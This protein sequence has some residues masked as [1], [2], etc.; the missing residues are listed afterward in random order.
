MLFLVS[1]GV[2]CFAVLVSIVSLIWNQPYLKPI[3]ILLMCALAGT[4]AV[5][6]RKVTADSS[7]RSATVGTVTS[8]LGLAV[9]S[10][11][12]LQVIFETGHITDI[13]MHLVFAG[14]FAVVLV[15]SLSLGKRNL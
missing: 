1:R 7:R 15:K 6:T 2:L 3:D 13:V 10:L 14:A 9:V 11:L 5:S 4:A 8:A 12:A